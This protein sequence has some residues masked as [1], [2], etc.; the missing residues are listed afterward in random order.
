MESLTVNAKGVFNVRSGA[1]RSTLAHAL[2]SSVAQN[3]VAPF[4]GIMAIRLGASNLQLGYLSAWPNL[5]SVA[6][7]LVGGAWLGRTTNLRATT[8]WLFVA[9]RIFFLGLAAV[10]WFAPDHQVWALILF[11]VLA[12]APGAAGNIGVQALV[13]ELWSP[14]DRGRIFAARQ[15]VATGASMVVVLVAGFVLDRLPSPLGYQLSF[16]LAWAVSLLEIWYLLQHRP[17]PGQITYPENAPA[18][19]SLGAMFAAVQ[20]ARSYL[21]FNLFLMIFYFS[22]QMPWPIFNRF[23]VTYLEADN[24]WT[25]ILTI[26]SSIGVMVANMHWAKLAERLGN[27]YLL[28]Y[29]T[30]VMA[31]MPFLY[32]GFHS[33]YAIA[34]GNFFTGAG[35]AGIT[36]LTLN[37]VLERAPAGTRTLFMSFNQALVA[38]SGTL[39][40]MVGGYLMDHM[41]IDAALVLAGCLR[42]LAVAGLFGLYAYER[43]LQSRGLLL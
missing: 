17:D 27:L 19:V 1:Y 36:L 12:S 41:D 7:L 10:P 25:S 13:A 29:A 38:V 18:P 37:I 32:A 23:N 43:R 8:A 20:G 2:T 35:A 11:W 28:R 31:I 26:T 9:A 39:A 3:L 33:L 6:A 42:V 15:S 34:L 21:R 24:T 22:W 14:Q 5:I 30:A 40:P 16:A 4:V